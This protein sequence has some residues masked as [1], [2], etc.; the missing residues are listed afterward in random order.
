MAMFV[1]LDCNSN[2]F[3]CECILSESIPLTRCFFVEGTN[4]SLASVLFPAPTMPTPTSTK[5]SSDSLQPKS[6][7]SLLKAKTKLPPDDH[8]ESSS[9]ASSDDEKIRHLAKNGVHAMSVDGSTDS[10]LASFP[11]ATGASPFYLPLAN[12]SVS[13]MTYFP[14]GNSPLVGLGTVHNNMFNHHSP[15]FTNPMQSMFPYGSTATAKD[16]SSPD[17]PVTTRHDETNEKVARRKTSQ[18]RGPSTNMTTATS[19][20][21][22]TSAA[23]TGPMLA[24]PRPA[25]LTAAEKKQRCTPNQVCDESRY[26]SVRLI[27]YDVLY[28]TVLCKRDRIGYESPQVFFVFFKGF[29]H[30]PWSPE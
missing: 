25:V 15:L 2:T 11:S 21:T 9:T 5:P 1:L 18:G 22:A 29:S 7:S 24:V 13:P 27:R 12:S 20:A 8:K 19:V 4:G 17:R 26:I 14:F 28:P 16:S 6:A 3:C 23:I 10:S 30:H